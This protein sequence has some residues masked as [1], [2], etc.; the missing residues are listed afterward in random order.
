MK[1]WVKRTLL[2][3]GALI[4]VLLLGGGGFV[5]S[6]ASAY[7]SSVEKIYDVPKP[8]ITRSS[9]P[10]VLAR[11]KHIAESLAPCASADCHGTDNAGGKP[12]VMGPVGTFTG[13]NITSAGLGSV[14]DDGE[15]ARL[16]RYGVK[17]DGRT[18]RFMPCHDWSWLPDGDLSAL[19]SYLRTVPPVEKPNGPLSVGVLAK[20]LDRRDVFVVDVARRVDIREAGKAPP[21]SPTKEYGEYIGRLCQGCHGVKLSGGPIPGTPPDFPPPPNLTPHASG[22]AGWSYEDFDKLLV[23]GI[24]KGGKKVSSYMP[25]EAFGRLDET[26][27]RA[28]YLYLMALEP[29]EYGNR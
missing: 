28:L 22:L 20:V 16:I 21:P 7:D 24:S 15:L 1:V 19:V 25:V 18:V 2:G 3:A 8:S 9:D 4:G 12:L 26:E 14:Y 23:Q 11:G 10:Q 27:K 6:Q 17:K 29:V 13:P 5:L